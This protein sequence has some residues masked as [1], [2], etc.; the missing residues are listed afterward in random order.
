MMFN[1]N[2]KIK[3]DFKTSMI[4]S[5]IKIMGKIDSQ[6]NITLGG[7]VEGDINCNSIIITETGFVKGSIKV[8]NAEIGGEIDGNIYADKLHILGT[9]VIKGK[10]SYKSIEIEEGAEVEGNFSQKKTALKTIKDT[11]KKI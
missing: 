3:N 9:A 6:Q 1:K 10:L 7:N 4:G 11:D 2:P 5:D 8:K